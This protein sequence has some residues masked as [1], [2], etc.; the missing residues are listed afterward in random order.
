VVA[1]V[2]ANIVAIS[3]LL[4][5]IVK[6]VKVEIITARLIGQPGSACWVGG[7]VVRPIY[8]VEGALST[9]LPR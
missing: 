5:V 2:L 8:G 9:P 3:G 6:L 4:I 7:K 1:A